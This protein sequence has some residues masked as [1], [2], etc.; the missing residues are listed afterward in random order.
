MSPEPVNPTDYLIWQV[1]H[2]HRL[3]V[4]QRF[5][6]L[7]LFR[8]QGRI[9]FA[10]Y[11]QN[12]RTHGELAQCLNVQPATITKMLQRMEQNEFVYR[13]PDE[14]DQ[15]ISR[16]FLTE[17][18]SAYHQR[19]LHIFS[20][21]EENENEGFTDEELITL[22]NL[23]SRVAANLEKNISANIVPSSEAEA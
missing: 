19:V 10:L 2:N 11:E 7:Q 23:L 13:Q 22:R 4:E 3:L 6:V 17:K 1:C 20:Q 5:E 12:G 14:K 21:L 16:V 8:G 18:G 9:L 15:R